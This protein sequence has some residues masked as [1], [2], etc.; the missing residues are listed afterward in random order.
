MGDISAFRSVSDG[1]MRARERAKARAFV[2]YVLDPY[3]RERESLRSAGTFPEPPSLRAIF[4]GAAVVV[5]IVM[6][7]AVWLAFTL[8][9]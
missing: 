2:R 1:Y 3:M 6:S 4:I 8:W 7:P 9:P 5:A